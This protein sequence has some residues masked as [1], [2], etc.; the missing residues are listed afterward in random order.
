M[1]LLIGGWCARGRLRIG[2]QMAPPL[3]KPTP[4]A[5]ANRAADVGHIL[6][7]IIATSGELATRSETYSVRV[8]KLSDLGQDLW[9]LQAK[10]Q[11]LKS[12]F[13]PHIVRHG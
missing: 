9:K 13:G 3:P 10:I 4:R 2:L 6:A 7:C 11:K 1:A 5:A 8:A 12:K